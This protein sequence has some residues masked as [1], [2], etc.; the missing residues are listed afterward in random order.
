MDSTLRLGYDAFAVA[1]SQV[2]D[3][4][5]ALQETTSQSRRQVERLMDGGWSGA[6]ADSFDNAWQ[7]WLT[8][9]ARVRGALEDI[10]AALI[11]TERDL[12]ARDDDAE[13]Q[14]AGLREAVGP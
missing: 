5:A 7:D 2:R 3:A 4:V 8:G 12:T 1:R 13:Q 9:A 14:L 10:E 11:S 6:A